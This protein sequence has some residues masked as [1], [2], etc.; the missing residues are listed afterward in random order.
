MFRMNRNITVYDL[1]LI[2]YSLTILAEGIGGPVVKAVIRI[3]LM[4]I[5][6]SFAAGKKSFYRISK[7]LFLYFLVTSVPLIFSLLRG[8]ITDDIVQY[9]MYINCL[10]FCH[11]YFTINN[12]I[13]LKTILY[14][15]FPVVLLFFLGGQILNIDIFWRETFSDNAVRLGGLL[16]NP[17]ELGMLAAA[18]SIIIIS[19]FG[20]APIFRLLMLLISLFV[21]VKTGSRSAIVALFVSVF[22]LCNRRT[23]I[24]SLILLLFVGILRFDL[25]LSLLPRADITDD[26]ISL[27][28]RAYTW[29]AAF[30]TLLPKYW[31]IGAGFQQFPGHNIGIG[32]HMAHNTFIQLLIGGGIIGLILGLFLSIRL[33][34][35]QSK[36]FSAV[37]IVL[38]IN[39]FTEFGYFGLF[40]H[41][42]LIFAIFASSKY[43]PTNF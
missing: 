26:L 22:Y 32:A 31:L 41:A 9:L 38:I 6:L 34:T 42:V 18:S 30:T 40:N 1:L 28:G 13:T 2:I 15:T 39:S 11:S 24:L 3:L 21:L 5:M 29:S 27:T 8:T 17:N 4:A 36:L 12:K 16:I 25:V 7:N 33:W 20:K 19:T 43:A 37:F 23:R 10:V 35:Q 14:I